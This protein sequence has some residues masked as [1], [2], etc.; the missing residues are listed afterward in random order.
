MPR[1]LASLLAAVLVLTTF[2]APRPVI[3]DEPEVRALWV[4]SFNLGPNE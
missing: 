2:A 4:D 3:A 1:S